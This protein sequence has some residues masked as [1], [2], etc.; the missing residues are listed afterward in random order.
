[1]LYVSWNDISCCT[2]NVS[3]WGALSATVTFYSANCM[4]CTHIV[5]IDSALHNQH[6]MTLCHIYINLMLKWAVHAINKL[7]RRP[8]LLMYRIFLRQLT[9]MDVDHCGRWTQIFSNKAYELKTS[10]LF[11]KCNFYVSHLHLAP[12]LGTIKTEFAPTSFAA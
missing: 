2:N 11:E 3:A 7:C 5:A 10:Q 9:V 1:M 12:M 8:K 4:V 6:A